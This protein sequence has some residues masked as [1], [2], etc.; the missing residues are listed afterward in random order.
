VAILAVVGVG[1][2]MRSSAKRAR[3]LLPLSAAVSFTLLFNLGALRTEDRFLLPQ[4]L[5]LLPYAAL[6]FE[7]AAVATRARNVRG[8]RGHAALLAAASALA[9][10]P[11]VLGV[12]SLD[13]T[14]LVDPRYAA[15]RFLAT[16]PAGTHIEVLGSIKFLPRLPSRLVAVRPGVEPLALRQETSGV[17][18][19]VDARMDPRPRA[20]ELIVLATE[21]SKVE[22]TEPA[23]RPSGFGL[24][25]YQDTTTRALLGR[26]ADG[27]LG[28][29]RVFRA[30]CLL[31]WPLGCRSVHGSTGGEVWI[32]GRSP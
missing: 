16:F 20:P 25:T 23:T 19:L 14:L 28:Y 24:S 4:S 7:R 8:A 26:L 10:A 15:E 17:L 22:M 5:L 32:Y 11:A 2:A 3:R 30:V 18:E 1:L 27:S 9:L 21:L 12:A 6:A 29:T 13:G 31:P